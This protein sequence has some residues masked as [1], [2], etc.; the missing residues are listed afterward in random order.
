MNIRNLTNILWKISWACGIL[1]V[2]SFFAML[3]AATFG[4]TAIF[5]GIAEAYIILGFPTYFVLVP[6]IVIHQFQ[7]GFKKAREA[8]KQ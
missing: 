3:I 2:L 8:G 5:R 6:W 1:Y 4:D 7:M